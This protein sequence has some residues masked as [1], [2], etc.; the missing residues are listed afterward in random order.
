MS[1]GLYVW[2]ILAQGCSNL[3]GH[4][5]N[6]MRLGRSFSLSKNSVT[7]LLHTN[8][9]RPKTAILMLN[10]GGPETTED[11]FHFLL[12]LFNDREVIWLPFQ[13]TRKV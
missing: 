4:F 5:F 9:D 6:T 1:T 13:S 3:N 11:V 10:M 12:R 8:V 7:K 2:P